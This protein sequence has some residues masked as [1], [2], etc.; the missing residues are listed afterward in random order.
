MKIKNKIL[1]LGSI[2]ILALAPTF[3]VSSYFSKQKDDKNKEDKLSPDFGQ[4]LNIAN[5][6]IKEGT[7]KTIDSIISFLK[8]EQNKLVAFLNSNDEKTQNQYKSTFE[9]AIYVKN[10]IIYFE[11]NKEAILKKPQNTAGF[12]IVFPFVVAKNEKFEMSDISF[13][14]KIYEEIRVGSTE[15]TNY[16]EQLGMGTQNKITKKSTRTNTVSKK[17][18][19]ELIANYFNDLNEQLPKMLLEEKD[20]PRF[21]K[22]LSFKHEIDEVIPK[23]FKSWQDYIQPKLNRKFIVFDIE[24]NKNFVEKEQEQQKKDDEPITKPD[25]VPGDKPKKDFDREEQIQAIPNLMP[26]VSS[27]YALK[28]AQTLINNFIELDAS[29]KQEMFFFNNPI[30]TRYKYT[31]QAVNKSNKKNSLSVD[32]HIVDQVTKKFRPYTFELEVNNTKAQ[33]ALNLVYEQIIN[34][35]KNLFQ[36]MIKSLGVDEKIDYNQLRNDELRDSLYN[37]ITTAVVLTNSESYVKESNKI[38][39]NTAAEYMKQ[40]DE[41]VIKKGIQQSNNLLLTSLFSSRINN[42]D[43]F[44]SLSQSLK[45]VLLRFKA[46]TKI[47]EKIIKTKF[48]QSGMDLNVINEYYNHVNLKISR[49]I[50]S[51]KIR[52]IDIMD[53]YDNYTTNVNEV[54]NNFATLAF[55]VDNKPMTEQKNKEDLKKAYEIA[56]AQIQSD[57]KINTNVMN[58]VGY[59][60]SALSGIILLSSLI[61]IGVRKNELKVL[62]TKK[63]LI[64]TFSIIAIVLLVSI[65]MIVL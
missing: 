32:I 63:L 60:L 43:Y 59:A 64:T 22:D 14:N 23:G 25:L 38:I 28:E 53:W 12:N 49:L 10:L 44:Y 37:L 41:S 33:Q 13:N 57:K 21:G 58:K 1:A 46:I 30:N 15:D 34:A 7:T 20:I 50:A 45:N 26:F 39:S 11:R 8:N 3:V 5:E 62:K 47:N 19:E 24:Q 42:N 17:K 6:K 48:A 36:Q 16:K 35:N 52:T 9:K 40:N 51:A 2:P 4:F 65:M 54:M 18:F 56:N 55:L 61:F 27:K 31:V 29:R